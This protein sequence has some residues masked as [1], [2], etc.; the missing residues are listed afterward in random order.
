MQISCFQCYLRLLFVCNFAS[1]CVIIMENYTNSKMIDVVPTLLRKCRWC[2]LKGTSF[3]MFPAR[4]VP[5]SQTFLAVVQRLR[6]NGTFRS[7]NVDRCQERTRWVLDFEPQILETV[8]EN[9]STSTRQLIREF[10]VF[11]KG[12]YAIMFSGCKHCIRRQEF[13]EWV[14]QQC[15]DQPDFLRIL[16]FAMKR[17]LHVTE[18]LTATTPIF[19]STNPGRRCKFCKGSGQSTY[20]EGHRRVLEIT[21]NILKYCSNHKYVTV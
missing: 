1:Q 8:E 3:V 4:S 17:V 9:P 14:I 12:C 16:F 6:E 15:V 19:S 11:S 2:C 7:R 13:C 10:Q 5:H 21:T 18:F 20:I